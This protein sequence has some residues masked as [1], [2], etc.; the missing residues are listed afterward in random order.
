MKDVQ[1]RHCF[2]IANG[3][4]RLPV[5]IVMI[6]LTWGC[7]PAQQTSTGAPGRGG[8]KPSMVYL[9]KRPGQQKIHLFKKKDNKPKELH[10]SAE[11]WDCPQDPNRKMVPASVKRNVRKNKDL[12]EN[13]PN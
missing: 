1:S 10:I 2:L 8:R 6:C 13:G 4:M 9:E 3:V 7:Q 5:F 11:E 12:I